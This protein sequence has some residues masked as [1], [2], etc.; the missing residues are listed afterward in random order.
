MKTSPLRIERLLNDVWYAVSMYFADRLKSSLMQQQ[1]KSLLFCILLL[2]LTLQRSFEQEVVRWFRGQKSL[3]SEILIEYIYMC[4][5][6]L[7]FLMVSFA[8]D[9]LSNQSGTAFF[10]GE[11]VLVPALVLLVGIAILKY[12][13]HVATLHKYK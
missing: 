13:E 2:L 12:A 5:R 4:S 3:W 8:I 1:E 9:M 6:T 11:S 7:A 10:W